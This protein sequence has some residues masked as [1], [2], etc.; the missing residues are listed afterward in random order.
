LDLLTSLPNSRFILVGDSGEQDLELYAAL[1]AEYPKQV[2]GI[3]IRDPTIYEDDA[4]GVADPTGLKNIEDFFA[5][6]YAVRQRE[7]QEFTSLSE[8][9]KRSSRSFD[10]YFSSSSSSSPPQLSGSSISVSSQRNGTPTLATPINLTE[11]PQAYVSMPSTPQ[12]AE[13]FSGQRQASPTRIVH[14][15]INQPKQRSR[16]PTSDSERKRMDL[17]ARIYKARR[18]IPAHIPFRVFRHPEE[19]VE[20]LELI[21]KIRGSFSA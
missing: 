12:E 11:E 8:H 18:S 2:L 13:Y 6:L 16:E 10:G 1:A 5:P 15:S 9:R 3:F 4:R 19:C 21:D 17:Q 7:R 14:H 20:A